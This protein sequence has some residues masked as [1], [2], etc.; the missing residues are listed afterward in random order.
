MAALLAGCAGAPTAPAIATDAARTRALLTPW[1]TVIGG[2][3]APPGALFGLSDRTGT[4]A[5]VR[6]IAP[7]AVAIRDNELLVV[8]SGADRLWRLD[9]ALN[10]LSPIA[11]APA[12]P[13][14]TVALG[15]DLSAW[16]HDPGARK[17]LR[18]AHDGRLLQTYSARHAAPSQG[19]FTLVDGGATLLLADSGLRQW[20]ELRPVG[21][22]AT[23]VRPRWPDGQ[24]V[25][26]VDGLAASGNTVY[27]LDRNLA[28]VYLVDRA[29]LVR[30]SLGRGDLKQ[31]V[32]IAADGLGGVFVHDAQDRSLKLLRPGLATLVLN[33]AQLQVQ[34]IGGFAVHGRMLVV[35]DRLTG[36]VMIHVMQIPGRR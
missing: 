15:P 9:P 18:F 24:A 2:F 5:F 25:V 33:S 28:Q 17:I 12:N 4:G 8:D 16:V 1:R 23:P 32:A 26:A 35:S 7:T 3:L 22:F 20:I 19:A 36:Q 14:T 30:A 31:P 13:F 34:V 6:L 10:T 11:G 29:G 27:V 21:S